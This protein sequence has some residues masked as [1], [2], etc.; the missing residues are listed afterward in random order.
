MELL[1]NKVTLIKGFI[2]YSLH[3]CKYYGN[4]YKKERREIVMMKTNVKT[5]S[6]VKAI[7]VA[8]AL[9]H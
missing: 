7:I 5:D 4:L 9:C 6:K 2:T 1:I 3:K 8:A